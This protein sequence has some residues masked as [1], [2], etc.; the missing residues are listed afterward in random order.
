[1]RSWRTEES[2]QKMGNRYLLRE[3]LATSGKKGNELGLVVDGI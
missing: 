1:M 2:I 3:S